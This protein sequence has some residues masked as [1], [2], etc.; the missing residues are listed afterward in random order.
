MYIRISAKSGDGQVLLSPKEEP[1]FFTFGKFEVIVKFMGTFSLLLSVHA[2][3][4]GLVEHY[5]C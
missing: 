4:S 3:I 5:H 1:Y 2:C